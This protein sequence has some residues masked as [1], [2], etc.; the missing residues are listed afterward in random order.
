MRKLLTFAILLLAL[1]PVNALMINEPSFKFKAN[2]WLKGVVISS[3]GDLVAFGNDN[4]LYL[5]DFNGNLLWKKDIKVSC[6]DFSGRYVAVGD[7]DGGIW[8]FDVNGSL[9]WKRVCNDSI[10][11]IAVSKNGSVIVGSGHEILHFSRDGKLIWKYRTKICVCS[12][13]ISSNG[14]VTVAGDMQNTMYIFKQCKVCPLE[15]KNCSDDLPWTCITGWTVRKYDKMRIV[16]PNTVVISSDGRYVAVCDGYYDVYMFDNEGHLLWRNFLS[17][18]PTSIAISSDGSYIAVGCE[19]GY[20]Y[21]FD[22]TGKILWKL[23]LISDTTSVDITSDGRFVVAGSGNKVYFFGRDSRLIWKS[24]VECPI[25]F[26]GVSNNGRVVAGSLNGLICFFRSKVKPV[27]DFEFSP[28]NPKVGEKVTFVAKSSA[29]EYIWDFGDGNI[30]KTSNATVTH[31]YSKP[32][33][34]IIKLTVR[35]E[36]GLTNSTSKVIVVKAIA[37]PKKDNPNPKPTPKPTPTPTPN[38]GWLPISLPKIPGFESAIGILA[39][40]TVGYAIGRK[41]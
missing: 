25:E 28:K 32:G 6:L 30:I 4:T 1:I 16:H 7:G 29:S 14:D 9:L 41:R 36:D 19:N 3:K 38:K 40:V 15:C 24:D 10:E 31:A 39:V 8:L 20:L 34:Y 18:L 21:L 2:T 11:A 22:K 17:G 26:V 35:S 5:F 37:N 27:A 12:V 23:N 33:S 13:D